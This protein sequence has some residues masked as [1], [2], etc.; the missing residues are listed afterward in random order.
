M[1]QTGLERRSWPLAISKKP[2]SDEEIAVFLQGIFEALDVPRR[3]CER[4]GKTVFI[5]FFG[6][7]KSGKDSITEEVERVIRRV[8]IFGAEKL[9][10]YWPRETAEFDEVRKRS[11]DDI[12]VFQAIHVAEVES[13]M[14]NLSQDRNFHVVFNHRGPI[15]MLY[16]YARWV[17]EGK[18]S[19]IHREG[20]RNRL[21]DL[22]RLKA[23]DGNGYLIDAF[24]YLVCSPEEALRREYAQ[25]ITRE[26]GSNMNEQVLHEA[27]HI[28]DEV[29][30]HLE[31][32]VPGLPIFRID[33]T[34]QTIQD[35]VR[36]IFHYLLPTLRE[37]FSVPPA[38]ILSRSLSLLEK[39][40]EE[41][42][43]FEE[44]LRLRG[45]VSQEKLEAA[46]WKF[47]GVAEQDDTY[48]NYSPEEKDS[49]GFSAKIMRIRRKNKRFRLTFKTAARDMI[50]SHR[51]PLE[52]EITA[53]EAE[54]MKN[55]YPTIVRTEKSR[56]YYSRT[57][58]VGGRGELFILHSDSV[59]GL[60]EFT[61][62]CIHGSPDCTHSRELLAL[63][64]ELVFVP[65]DIVDVGYATLALRQRK[66]K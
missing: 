53:E 54:R 16:W 14:L 27:M 32:N 61:E 11:T 44:Q 64:V 43:F 37:R 5:D 3:K 20:V 62:I 58:E 18:C 46:G 36:E 57:V 50:F 65:A 29:L 52:I 17:R 48:L 25:A 6:P 34:R 47:F 49:D 40:T 28:Y 63:A 1:P 30:R 31:V 51:K 12:L 39:T 35:S 21:Y 9:N 41:M 23:N 15:D 4:A 45:L 38:K 13:R 10:V 59:Q 7:P 22:L 42:P 2:L 33:T 8:R 55:R 26:R 66:E 56:A 60:G 24:F 19:E